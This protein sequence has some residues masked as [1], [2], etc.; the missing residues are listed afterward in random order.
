MGDPHTREPPSPLVV[1]GSCD[2]L[3]IIPRAVPSADSCLYLDLAGSVDAHSCNF[4]RAAVLKAVDS[5]FLHILLGLHT[6]DYVSSTGVGT[7]LALLRVL[8]ERNGSLT[9]VRPHPKVLTVFQLMH[10]QTFFPCTDSL[11]EAVRLLRP[12][13]RDG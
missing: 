6:V 3:R 11:E 4:L 8:M 5:G 9:I 13:S 2:Y 10:L 1:D 12:L 7:L